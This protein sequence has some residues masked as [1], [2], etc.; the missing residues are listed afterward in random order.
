MGSPHC[1][2]NQKIISPQ[3]Q[4]LQLPY[5]AYSQRD[6]AQRRSIG[7]LLYTPPPCVP[8]WKWERG[9][10][11]LIHHRLHVRA[12][13]PTSTSRLDDVTTLSRPWV[14]ATGRGKD[15][16][17]CH[18]SDGRMTYSLVLHIIPHSLQYLFLCLALFFI[19][20]LSLFVTSAITIS[21]TK[22]SYKG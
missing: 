2:A 21:A 19:A 9:T 12:C 11:P 15:Q 3:V 16:R 10:P 13:T 5:T 7:A 14:N 6:Y 22:A 20:I 4:Q 8:Q 1:C 17:V 18:P